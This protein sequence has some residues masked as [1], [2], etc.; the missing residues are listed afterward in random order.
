MIQFF[1]KLRLK[2]IQSRIDRLRIKRAHLQGMRNAYRS[3]GYV[4]ALVEGRIAATDELI[5]QL[6]AAGTLERM[7]V[8]EEAA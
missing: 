1:R 6:I 5:G 3:H 8:K 2:R 7:K 4:D